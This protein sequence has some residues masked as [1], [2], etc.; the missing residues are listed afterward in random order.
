M[1]GDD[2][3][4]DNNGGGIPVNSSGMRALRSIFLYFC[5]EAHKLDHDVHFGTKLA[6]FKQAANAYN[7][8]AK[9]HGPNNAPMKELFLS[10]QQAKKKK[11]KEVN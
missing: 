4:V 2:N 7:K 1:V 9:S 11:E 3:G 6:L 8:V 5:Y 10:R